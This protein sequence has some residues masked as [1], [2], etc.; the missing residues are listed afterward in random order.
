MK[1]AAIPAAAALLLIVLLAAVYPRMTR[2]DDAA[3]A[4]QAQP[5]PAESEWAGK[6]RISGADGEE[7]RGV[8]G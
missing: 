5:V 3:P 1:R 6:L 2:K 8:H 7:H 4:A